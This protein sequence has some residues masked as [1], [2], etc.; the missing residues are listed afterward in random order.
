M[1]ERVILIVD[2][3]K[4]IESVYIPA[5]KMELSKM[6]LGKWKDYIFT[7]IHKQTM[8]D[9]LDYLSDMQNCVDVLV[10]DYDFGSEKT[11]SNGSEFVR[12][13]RERIN[14]YCQIVFYTMQG[15]D[16]I[17]KSELVQLV[18]SDVYKLVDKSANDDVM[19]T[20]IFEAATKRNPIVESL[21]RFYSNHSN[22]LSTYNYT[23]FSESIT[24]DEIINHIRMDDEI[25][26]LF[27]EKLLNKSI[28]QSIDV[29]R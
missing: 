14:R 17:D 11:F 23:V 2:D 5:Y 19:A 12:Y 22:M 4:K 7:F 25:G 16:S 15:I 6:N 1:L 10:V 26:R 8:K 21:E 27:V 13:V 20:A 3:N 28:L 29:R 9:A 18:N 24:I